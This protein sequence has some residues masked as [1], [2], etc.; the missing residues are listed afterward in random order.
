M[1]ELETIELTDTVEDMVS[2]V[3]GN[4]IVL[5][6]SEGGGGG[7]VSLRFDFTVAQEI[8]TCEH[9]RGSINVTADVF[10]SDNDNIIVDR[11]FPVNENTFEVRF[12]VGL[13]QTGYAI[14]RF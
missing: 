3:N 1:A 13:P 4:F 6:T 14:L 11:M 10:N 7:Q 12:P 8:W 2:K 9:N 5:S